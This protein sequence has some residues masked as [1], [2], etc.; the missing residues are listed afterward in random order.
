MKIT[1]RT[2]GGERRPECKVYTQMETKFGGSNERSVS[3]RVE[4]KIS[5]F[6]KPSYLVGGLRED[7]FWTFGGF[8]F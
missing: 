2:S 6:F 5:V 3:F 4:R 7:P 1:A 8:D